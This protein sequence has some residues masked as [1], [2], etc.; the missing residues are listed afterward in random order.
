MSR[1]VNRVQLL[2]RIGDLLEGSTA[3]GG[4]TETHG[5]APNGYTDGYILG[6][7]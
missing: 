3:W 2:G 5:S 1:S 6:I 7:P 4:C